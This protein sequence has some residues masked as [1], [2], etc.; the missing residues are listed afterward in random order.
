MK[1]SELKNLTKEQLLT[2]IKLLRKN[3]FYHY[4]AAKLLHTNGLN[5]LS[6]THS[7][8]SSEE[9]VKC[10]VL[11]NLYTGAKQMDEEIIINIFSSHNIR[12]SAVIAT[13]DELTHSSV[14]LAKHLVFQIDT[15]LKNSPQELKDQLQSLKQDYLE[16]LDKKQN[17][18]S[19]SKKFKKWYKKANEYKNKGLYV[20]FENGDWTKPDEFSTFQS[21]EANN[22]VSN[23]LF[24]MEILTNDQ[25]GFLDSKR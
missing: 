4:D 2:G 16:I 10:L 3:A 24:V 21:A 23:I 7:I 14:S 17:L 13:W 1:L 20:D 19:N 25:L 11:F 5:G 9:A 6:I 8:L 22:I 15:M 12:H 18:N